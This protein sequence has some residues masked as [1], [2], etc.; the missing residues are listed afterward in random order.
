MRIFY[1][2]NVL[3]AAKRRIRALF[4]RHEVAVTI[5]GG[6]DSTVCFF[7][8]LE[9]AR[10]MGR[11]PLKVIFL[12]QEAEYQC[13]I[14]YI[15]TLM[16]MP[17]V[18]P[19]WY[20]MPCYLFNANSS[21][22]E[23]LHCWD[24][25]AEDVWM[26]P[27][28]PNSIKVNT[29]GVGKLFKN[30]LSAVQN[31]HFGDNIVF[32]GGVRAEESPTRFMALTKHEA[33]D[34]FTWGK[35]INTQNTRWVMY[36]LYDWS[37]KDIW[38]AIHDNGWPYCSLYDYQYMLGVPTNRMR[39]SSLCHEIS[40]GGLRYLQE[41]ETETWN[42]LARRV[43]GVATSGK[44]SWS[45][46]CPSK[47]PFMFTSWLEYR[48]YLAENLLPPAGQKKMRRKFEILDPKWGEEKV[49]LQTCIGSILANDYYGT[50]LQNF[51]SSRK[52]GHNTNKVETVGAVTT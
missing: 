34:G 15:R 42:R 6:K 45:L 20:Q 27:K 44:F 39:L 5:S 23:W 4:E 24:P 26:R 21:A 16:A 13:G 2:E 32:L 52:F 25:E 46:S 28:E 51:T 31:Q 22:S 47:L 30:I 8:A 29:T 14:D 49:Y 11:L 19:Y 3:D 17:G 43:P 9:I 18:D 36:P 10:E 12:D 38:K 37:Y 41:I 48:D 33:V 40:S 35:I 50:Q 1:D 7:L